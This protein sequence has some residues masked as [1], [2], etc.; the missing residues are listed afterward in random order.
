MVSFE[1]VATYKQGTRPEDHRDTLQQLRHPLLD[2]SQHVPYSRLQ[3]GLINPFLKKFVITKTLLAGPQ[4]QGVQINVSGC[5]ATDGIFVEQ[6]RYYHNYSPGNNYSLERALPLEE[7]ILEMLKKQTLDEQNP[8]G[9]LKLVND[10]YERCKS[11]YADEFKDFLKREFT[12]QRNKDDSGMR[13]PSDSDVL[14]SFMPDTKS[15][16]MDVPNK[17]VGERLKWLRL[18]PE[19]P[20]ASV[21]LNE[22]EV[23]MKKSE[24]HEATTSTTASE[25]K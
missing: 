18:I 21:E 24:S 14:H 25:S 22:F 9:R 4:Y 3:G 17:R 19:D 11:D 12:S 16:F 23:S 13:T 7:A 8:Q 2:T 20:F 10:S 15:T 5:I 1:T 6:P